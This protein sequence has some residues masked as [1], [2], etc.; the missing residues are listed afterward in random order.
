[1]AGALS[2]GIGFGLQNIVSNFVSGLI[3]LI[4]RPVSEGDWVEVGK[5]QGYISRISVRSTVIETFDKSEVIVPNSDLISGTVTNFTR[6]NKTGRLIVKVSVAYGTDTRRVEGILREI[7]EANPI[8]ALDPAPTVL[9]TG[10]GADGLDF[11]VRVILR[12]VGFMMRVASDMRHEIAS[13]FGTEK[14]EIPFAQRDIWLR[15]PEALAGPAS[16]AP[17]AAGPAAAAGAGVLA[18][19]AAVASGLVD[20]REESG[21]TALYDDTEGDSATAE[22]DA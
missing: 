18:G 13:R 7:A 10:F 22:D 11:E 1:V 17:S 6:T 14:I 19:G 12:D 8:V 5:T 9:F 15:N 16:A 4:E 21:S 3:L 20:P 2:L